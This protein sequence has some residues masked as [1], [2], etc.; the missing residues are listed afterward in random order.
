MNNKAMSLLV[1]TAVICVPTASALSITINVPADQPS[2]QAAIDAANGGDEVVVAPGTYF[3]A[4]DFSSKAITVRSSGGA[5]LTIIDAQGLGSVVT[6]Q[7]GEGPDTVLEGFTLTGGDPSPASGGGMY[8]LNGSPTVTDCIFTAN[9]ASYGGGMFNVNSSPT[10]TN[11]IFSDNTAL[12]GGGMYNV[13]SQPT[14]TNCTFSGNQATI[15][16][17]FGVGGAIYN[18]SFSTVTLANCSF[19]E[20]TCN[21]G[22][23][24]IYSSDSNLFV[25]DCTFSGNTGGWIATVVDSGTVTFT[26]CTFSGNTGP[27][28]T[29]AAWGTGTVTLTN[30]TFSSNVGEWTVGTSDTGNLTLANC[31]LW[32][33]SGGSICELLQRRGRLRGNGQPRRRSAVRR[34]AGTGRDPGNG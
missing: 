28:C 31:V 20:N 1:G 11:C 21:C 30:C 32:N 34:R 4:I 29:V 5:A 6:C 22:A 7:S 23:G 2:I 13:N 27:G 17:G 15:T 19:T 16:Q 12:Y 8:N 3:E 14:L 33:N 10:V 25:L 24:A 18:Q 9:T 26:N